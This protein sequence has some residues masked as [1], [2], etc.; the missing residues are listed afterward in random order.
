[1]ACGSKLKLPSAIGDN[2]SD[3]KNVSRSRLELPTFG[4]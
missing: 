1:M 3:E 2:E 4:L